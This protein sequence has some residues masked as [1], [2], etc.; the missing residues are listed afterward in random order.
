MSQYIANILQYIAN[1]NNMLYIATIYRNIL[2]YRLKCKAQP[3]SSVY[4]SSSE[5]SSSSPTSAL[6]QFS[7]VSESKRRCTALASGQSSLLALRNISVSRLSGSIFFLNAVMFSLHLENS[8]S[9]AL[10]V[11]WT[12]RVSLYA[13]V[14]ALALALFPEEL[15]ARS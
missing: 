9:S 1:C 13:D 14:I 15:D 10:V 11:G 12:C 2:Q 8:L 6:A 5:S 3:L 4:Y 7:G